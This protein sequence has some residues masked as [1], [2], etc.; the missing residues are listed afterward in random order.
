[1]NSLKKVIILISFL[2]PDAYKIALSTSVLIITWRVQNYLQPYKH[3]YNNEIEMLG[4]N[5]G[6]VTLLSGMI[7]N[8]INTSNSLNS[9]LL[10]IMLALNAIFIVQ[11]IYLLVANLGEKYTVFEQVNISL[12]HYLGCK[13]HEICTYEEKTR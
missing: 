7:Y 1:V 3:E 4:V 11:W 10:I 2:L 5:V 9:V 12:L 8:Q 13:D 6:I